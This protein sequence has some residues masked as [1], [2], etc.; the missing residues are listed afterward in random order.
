MAE[1]IVTLSEAL[2]PEAQ[3]FALSWA[4][5][6]RVIVTAETAVVE[7]N[8]YGAT[9]INA[10]SATNLKL[11]RTGTLNPGDKIMVARTGSGAWVILDRVATPA[12]LEA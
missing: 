4:I 11:A 2:A 8:L 5:V 6:S 10:R 12:E 1:P 3:Q 7:F 9:T